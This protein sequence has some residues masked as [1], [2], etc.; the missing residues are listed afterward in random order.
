[1]LGTCP[2]SRRSPSG[3]PGLFIYSSGKD[4]LPPIFG[5]Q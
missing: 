2:R 1:L 3:P 5:T 4:S